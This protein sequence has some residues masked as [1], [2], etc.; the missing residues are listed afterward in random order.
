[1]VLL[2]QRLGFAIADLPVEWI[3]SPASHVHIVRDSLRMVRDTLRARRHVR[4]LMD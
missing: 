3:N 2:A 4:R 1:V